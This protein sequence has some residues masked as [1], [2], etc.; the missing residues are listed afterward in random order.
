[1]VGPRI[2]KRDR[3]GANEDEEGRQA[4]RYAKSSI[5]LFGVLARLPPTVRSRVT[6]GEVYPHR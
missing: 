6:V 5:L 3:E 4:R 2:R 1:M